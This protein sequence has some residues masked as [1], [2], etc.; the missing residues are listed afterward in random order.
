MN[1]KTLTLFSAAFII[2]ALVVPIVAFAQQAEPPVP[3]GLI[4]FGQGPSTIKLTWDD[5]DDYVAGTTIR[6]YRDGVFL[7]D[8]VV[9]D[10]DGNLTGY[11]DPNLQPETDYTYTL[12]FIDSDG[13]ESAQSPPATAT[14]GAVYFNLNP[15]SEIIPVERLGDWSNAGVVGGIPDYPVGVN[16]MDYGA[17]GDGVADDT[18]A[19]LDA[20]AA[21]PPGQAVFLPA[22]SY[23]TTET[24][25]FT[26]SVV[27]RGAGPELTL[28]IQNHNDEGIQIGY[29]DRDLPTA[30]EVSWAGIEDLHLQTRYAFGR[31]SGVKIR[32]ARASNSWIK[33]IETSGF[34]YHGISLLATSHCEVR[35][36]FIHST[37][38]FVDWEVEGGDH[39]DPY[40]IV[41]DGMNEQLRATMV[42]DEWVFSEY[43]LVENN[44]LDWMRHAMII[45]KHNVNN[46]FGYNFVWT[47]WSH[48]QSET[49]CL[50]YHHPDYTDGARVATYILAE[51]NAFEMADSYGWH[52]T[53]TYFRNRAMGGRSVGLGL[54][55]NSYAIGNELPAHKHPLYG[56][57]NTLNARAGS[58][59]HGNYVTDGNGMQWDPAIADHNI[60]DSY[61]HESKPDFFSD[62]AW[63]CYGGDLMEQASDN[64]N[65]RRSPAE[66][67]YWSMM[68]PE[69]SPS[70]L[71]AYVQG[72]AVA[73]TWNNNSTNQVDFIIVRSSDNENFERLATVSGTTYTD[74]ILEGGQYYYYVRAMN[75]LGGVNGD[76]PGGESGPS[77]VLSVDVEG[78]VMDHVIWI[79]FCSH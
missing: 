60:P 24:I 12:S 4:A 26:K 9:P 10:N 31:A 51:G 37:Y 38:E 23:S 34:A 70:N 28:I 49:H 39:G 67:R 33:N 16:A 59:A 77:N 15:D 64:V 74:T 50:K 46:V 75:Y 8:C 20:I 56:I 73:L 52:H 72:N 36:S 6:I 63:P 47:N 58:F 57:N 35:D 69:E 76:Q 27:L 41:L 43:N 19:I 78:V 53:N 55:A 68:F 44:I 79:P 66:V 29:E 11:S 2:L 54:Q 25:V 32:L 71:Q 45:L 14:T 1:Q 30:P 62:L 48:V 17:V 18:Q 5:S 21:C 3:Q 13:T 7:Y 61:Y 22:G 65:T 42:H 40:G